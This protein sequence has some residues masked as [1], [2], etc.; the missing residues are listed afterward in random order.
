MSDTNRLRPDE[1][2]QR[3]DHFHALVDM[4]ESCIHAARY[5]PTE[6]RE[7]A[8]LAAIRYE[9]HRG[10]PEWRVEFKPI[11]PTTERV[12]L[13]PMSEADLARFVEAMEIKRRRP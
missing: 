8:M 1:R 10:I 4:L 5:T 3:D 11:D 2:Y 12:D 9:M 7:A 6:L 13:L